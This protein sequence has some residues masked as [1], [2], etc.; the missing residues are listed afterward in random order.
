MAASIRVSILNM[1]NLFLRNKQI[2]HLKYYIMFPHYSNLDPVIGL[3]EL[4]L[5]EICRML[6]NSDYKT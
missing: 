4:L 5:F 1:Y 6:S 3:A 2:Q